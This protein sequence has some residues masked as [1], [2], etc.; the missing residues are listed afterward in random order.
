MRGPKQLLI[1]GA[2]TFPETQMPFFDE[3]FHREELLPWYDHHLKG[4]DNGVME[5]PAVRFFVKNEGVTLSAATWPPAD[6][7]VAEF[8]LS[9]EKSGTKRS[10][11][12]GSLVEAAPEADGGSTSWSYPDPHW[13]A[14][15]TMVGKDGTPDHFARV[16]T[17]ATAP[18]DRDREFTGQGVLHL[19]ASSDQT[20]MD[21]MVKLSVL[22][23][24]EGKPLFIK[25]SQGWLRASH[26]AEDPV[27]TTDMRPFHSHQTVEPIE[28]AQVYALRVELLP[29]SFLVRAG[30]RIRL[31]ISNWDSL[32]ADA[33]MTHFYGQKVGTNTYHHDAANPSQLRLHERP[34]PE[35]PSNNGERA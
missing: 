34:R 13:V 15:V 2:S 18:F 20:D 4:A 30:E 6:V 29:M 28:P 5:R 22:P 26:R 10:L 11:N 9:S 25:V 32:I 16:V 1:V 19:F 3:E 23:E 7:A 35:Q 17:F 27:L 12:D 21:V 14:G 8:H 33:P 31:E 24:G